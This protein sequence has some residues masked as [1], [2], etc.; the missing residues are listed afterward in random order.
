MNHICEEGSQPLPRWIQPTPVDIFQTA[1]E[2]IWWFRPKEERASIPV[3]F[4]PFCG[5]SLVTS[6]A[7]D[8]EVAEP[9][10]PEDAPYR[11]VEEGI[12]GSVRWMRLKQVPV[13]DDI[14]KAA[15][16]VAEEAAPPWRPDGRGN[17]ELRQAQE[18]L[19]I[20][21]DIALNYGVAFGIAEMQKDRVRLRERADKL[22]RLLMA[23]VED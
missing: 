12:D 19:S 13:A 5:K 9:R 4:C 10:I 14:A 18:A 11:V 17:E 1:P 3:A 8:V 23:A 20:C 21:D 6:Q 2:H 15:E 22:Q 16:E 7:V